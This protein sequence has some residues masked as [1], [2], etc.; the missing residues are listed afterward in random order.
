MGLS[1]T[2]IAVRD[3]KPVLTVAFPHKAACIISLKQ[4]NPKDPR[5]IRR[6]TRRDR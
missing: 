6:Y 4:S 1:C 3:R 2:R 5:Q